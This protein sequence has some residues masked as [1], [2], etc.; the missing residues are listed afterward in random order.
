ARITSIECVG[1]SPELDRYRRELGIWYQ[2]MTYTQVE[3][4]AGAG[5]AVSTEP[6]HYVIH[7]L[8]GGC[9]EAMVAW[10][11]DPDHPPIDVLIAEMAQLFIAA[12]AIP[13]SSEW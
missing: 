13:P 11:E 3:R 8:V 10:L 6:T 9:N 1:V 7:A 12:G 4:L 5:E 2:D